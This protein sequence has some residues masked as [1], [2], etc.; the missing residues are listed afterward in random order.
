MWIFYILCMKSGKTSYLQRIIHNLIRTL[1]CLSSKLINGDYS[2]ITDFHGHCE[3]K[4]CGITTCWCL[5]CVDTNL[6]CVPLLIVHG[7]VDVQ[8][9]RVFVYGDDSRR[10]LVHPLSMQF[11]VYSIFPINTHLQQQMSVRSVMVDTTGIFFTL[12]WK[13]LPKLNWLFLYTKKRK[14][15]QNTHLKHKTAR[16]LLVDFFCFKQLIINGQCC[17]LISITF[18]RCFTS[19]QLMSYKMGSQHQVQCKNMSFGFV[20]IYLWN[21]EMDIICLNFSPCP[22]HMG[23]ALDDPPQS[24]RSQ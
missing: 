20:F 11:K 22:T 6:K 3:Q 7:L 21:L 1:I 24:Q 18:K 2:A 5:T 23:M 15:W 12:K 9:A 17:M 14:K 19:L 4:F 13:F 8:H 10:L 16:R